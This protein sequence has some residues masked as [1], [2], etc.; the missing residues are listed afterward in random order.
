MSL[1]R[2]LPFPAVT[3]VVAGV[4]SM[5]LP[6]FSGFVAEL[7]VLIGAWKAFPTATVIAG[8]GIVLGVAYTLRAV[9]K[10]FYSDANPEAEQATSHGH[11]HSGHGEAL[12]P[13]TL[14]EKLASVL[15]IATSLIIG[16]CPSL[17]LNWI[18]PCLQSP[19]FERVLKGGSL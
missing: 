3:F 17:L 9:Q 4:A 13:V 8:V 6:G 7:Q 2:L 14:P 19:L 10:A 5:G 1:G 18:E 15:L 16:L 11:G 12:D